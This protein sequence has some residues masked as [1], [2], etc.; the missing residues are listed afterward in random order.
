VGCAARDEPH[1][2]SRFNTETSREKLCLLDPIP[3]GP[4]QLCNQPLST[5]RQRAIE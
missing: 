5:T 2:L 4:K 3:D 1:G